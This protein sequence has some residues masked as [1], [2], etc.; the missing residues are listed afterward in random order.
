MARRI[1]GLPSLVIGCSPFDCI[2]RNSSML[3]A[4]LLSPGPTPRV[5]DTSSIGRSPASGLLSSCC[6]PRSS[7]PLKCV[8]ARIRER[9]RAN[10]NLWSPIGRSHLDQYWVRDLPRPHRLGSR[11]LAEQR[12]RH[13][14][15]CL[16]PPV[17][18]YVQVPCRATRTDDQNKVARAPGQ[19]LERCLPYMVE[20]DNLQLVC[21]LGVLLCE[22]SMIQRF[23]SALRR[24]GVWVLL[25]ASPLLMGGCP[26]LQDDVATAFET[27]VQSIMSSAVTLYFDQYRTN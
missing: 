1:V 25:A 6:R 14:R 21:A 16:G 12:D 20:V 23:R 18:V 26:E 15:V 10:Y 5:C 24:M 2:P 19:A 8:Y 13:G 3:A 7:T 4:N 22:K 27:A 11:P 17:S 9:P